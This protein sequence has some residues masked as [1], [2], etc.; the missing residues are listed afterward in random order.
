MTSDQPRI[1]DLVFAS[2][3]RRDTDRR[4]SEEVAEHRQAG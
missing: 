2:Q 3:I 1:G 4:L